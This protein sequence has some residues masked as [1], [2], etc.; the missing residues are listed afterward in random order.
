MQAP[1]QNMAGQSPKRRR[2]G[3]AG[4]LVIFLF[5]QVGINL[6]KQHFGTVSSEPWHRTV[7]ATPRKIPRTSVHKIAQKFAQHPCHGST[8]T[9]NA[10]RAHMKRASAKMTPHSSHRIRAQ[11]YRSTSDIV[12]KRSAEK[13]CQ[14]SKKSQRAT[15]LPTIAEE[16]ATPSNTSANKP[17]KHSVFAKSEMSA[18]TPIASE[19]TI[20]QS[21]FPSELDTNGSG[22]EHQFFKRPEDDIEI[23]IN[24]KKE[25]E[26]PLLGYQ[27]DSEE[28]PESRP[29]QTRTDDGKVGTIN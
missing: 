9:S 1:E 12:R 10:K 7:A 14:L 15:I 18:I 25:S 3:L 23:I 17:S 27:S 21:R 26:L 16:L 20:M 5:A 13:A 29:T 28:M 2:P 4:W 11:L 19:S 24:L 6:A 8:P 22:D